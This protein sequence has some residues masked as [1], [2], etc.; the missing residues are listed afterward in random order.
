MYIDRPVSHF[1]SYRNYYVNEP[2][3]SSH[4]LV[5]TSA[6]EVRFLPVFVCLCVC[7]Q[8]NSKSYGRIFIVIYLPAK[9]NTVHQVDTNI[10]SARHTR[11]TEHLQ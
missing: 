1:L 4:F 7:V 3:T 9:H 10:Q 11:L 5:I 6:K 2:T 8:D